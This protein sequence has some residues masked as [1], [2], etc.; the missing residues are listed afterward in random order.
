MTVLRKYSEYD[1]VCVLFSNVPL[2]KPWHIDEAIYQWY[3]FNFDSV[4][5]VVEDYAFYYRR[6]KNSLVPVGRQNRYIKVERESLLQEN[7]AVYITSKD[8]LEKGCLVGGKT[9]YVVMHREESVKINS[10]YEFWLAEQLL[11]RDDVYPS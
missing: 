3:L 11:R 5:S 4:I 8:L 6:G 2:R 7:G 1:V 10:A 9:G